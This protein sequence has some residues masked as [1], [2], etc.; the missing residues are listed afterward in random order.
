MHTHLHLSFSPFL[1]LFSVEIWLI[2]LFHFQFVEIWNIWSF[3][4]NLF[5]LLRFIDIN[6]F[7]FSKNFAGSVP[8][9]N[10]TPIKATTFTTNFELGVTRAQTSSPIVSIIQPSP[11]I[12]YN[13]I[14][15]NALKCHQQ[16]TDVRTKTNETE[17]G[18]TTTTT[19]NG[20][21]GTT[22][23]ITAT[24]Q[25]TTITTT[26]EHLHHQLISV[27]GNGHHTINGQS[28]NGGEP[29]SLQY[30]KPATDDQTVVWSE[31]ASDLLFWKL[32]GKKK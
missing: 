31:G 6:A 17:N 21:G 2:L 11:P 8:L 13:S 19:I 12:N 14:T 26:T 30:L 20:T 16:Q 4:C 15:S 24:T 27:T 22:T 18:T 1:F 29:E 3:A 28:T 7:S 25:K 9:G 5:H 23:K 32:K 10:Y